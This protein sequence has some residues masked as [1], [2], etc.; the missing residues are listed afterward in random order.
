M[1]RESDVGGISIYTGG[2]TTPLEPVRGD[3]RKHLKSVSEKLTHA[4]CSLPR[5]A[6]MRLV[7]Q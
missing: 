3:V 1:K 5:I 2:K 4:G 7:A 6:P